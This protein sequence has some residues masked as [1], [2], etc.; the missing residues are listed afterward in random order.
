MPRIKLYQGQLGVSGAGSRGTPQ[1]RV[2]FSPEDFD[3]S[4]IGQAVTQGVKQYAAVQQKQKI[5]QDAKDSSWANQSLATYEKGVIKD[6]DSLT[7]WLG[8]I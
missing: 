5:I 4:S 1:S 6:A 8:S 2:Q 7:K 3:S